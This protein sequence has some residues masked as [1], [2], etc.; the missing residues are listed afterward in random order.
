MSNDLP[1]R[2]ERAEGL[3]DPV[4]ELTA[5]VCHGVLGLPELHL[6]A[7]QLGPEL[8]LLVRGP[9]TGI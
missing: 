1:H 3:P 2:L 6:Q 4:P 9:C 7:L 8:G 5:G